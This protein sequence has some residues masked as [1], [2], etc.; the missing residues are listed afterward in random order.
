MVVTRPNRT[1]VAAALVGFVATALPAETATAQLISRNSA[2]FEQNAN[3]LRVRSLARINRY[4]AEVGVPPLGWDERLEASARLYGPRLAR[5]GT[6]VHSP[7]AERPNVGEALWMGPRGEYSIEGMIDYLGEEKSMFR[8]GIFPNVSTTGNWEDVSH[9]TQM[10]WRETT[11]VGCALERGGRSD[12]LI[13][14]FSPKGN[15]DGKRVP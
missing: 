14:H 8:P 13:C 10:I 2:L 7:R 1:L 11:A 9:Y 5:L 15:R 3:D 6:L 12:Y 4:R